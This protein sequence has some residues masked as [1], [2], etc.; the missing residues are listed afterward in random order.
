VHQHLALLSSLNPT[1][2]LS[3]F[4]VLGVFAVMFLEMGVLVAFFLPGDTLLFVA[5]YATVENNSLGLHLPLGWLLLAA[6]AGAVLGGQLGYEV[7][8]RAEATLHERPDSRFYKKAYATRADAFLHR[9]GAARTVVLSRFVPVVRTFASPIVGIAGM[10]VPAYSA[11]NLVGGVVWTV[12]II[13]AGHWLGH[14]PSIRR[15]VELIAVVVVVVSVVPA[16]IHIA[17]DHRE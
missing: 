6:A 14:I 10:P 3:T 17:R 16:L 13:L 11:W 8:R 2:L 12:P 15:Y 9:F 5:G 4:G 1:H 7:G